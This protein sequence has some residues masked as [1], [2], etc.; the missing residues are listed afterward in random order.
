MDA[1]RAAPDNL[2][3]REVVHAQD[4]RG[5][6]EILVRELAQE[7]QRGVRA[8]WDRQVRGQPGRG[9]PG[10]CQREPLQRPAQ[11]R[12]A[13]GEPLGQP[14]HVLDERPATALRRPAE[15]PPDQEIY[16]DLPPRDRQVGQ[17]PA[18][19]PVDT[20]G[21]AAAPWA[22][23]LSAHRPR[24]E[25][26]HFVVHSDLLHRDRLQVGEG[27]PEHAAFTRTYNRS[28][29]RN[30]TSHGHSKRIR[31]SFGPVSLSVVAEIAAIRGGCGDGGGG[32]LLVRASGARSAWSWC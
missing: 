15:E 29:V 25:G 31:A 9:A 2:L 14:F 10:Q 27:S 11:D 32:S 21:R 30:A 22:G 7:P 17:T 23:R 1:L 3:E 8:G 12:C 4:S 28:E 26:H 24:R 5:R 20:A 6:V 19:S 13:T 16:D 18:V